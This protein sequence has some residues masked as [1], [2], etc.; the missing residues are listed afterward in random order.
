MTEK[1]RGDIATRFQPGNQFWKARSTHGRK[2]IYDAPEKLQDAIEQY[3]EWVIDNP[4]IEYKPMIEQGMI[5]NAMIPKPIPMLIA[6][7]QNFCGLSDTQWAIYK[8]NPVFTEV[9]VQAELIIRA[10]K[11]T[12]A[13]VGFFNAN[14]IARDL[15]LRDASDVKLEAPQG[16][17]FNL[18]YKG[19]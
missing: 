6:G 13:S 7:C 9:I 10:H 4:L 2:P 3:F 19:E 5:A 1:E 15:G 18:N 12:G 14:I 8:N 11:L 16:V 17:V